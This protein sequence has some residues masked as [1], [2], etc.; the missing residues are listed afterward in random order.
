MGRVSST[1]IEAAIEKTRGWLFFFAQLLAQ[2]SLPRRRM[3]RKVLAF[4]SYNNLIR[5]LLS[6]LRDRLIVLT[7]RGE[8]LS[9]PNLK[10]LREQRLCVYQT[11]LKCQVYK[12]SRRNS[13]PAINTTSICL[14]NHNSRALILQIERPQQTTAIAPASRRDKRTNRMQRD[15]PAERL[16]A[17]NE[18]R[19]KPNLKSTRDRPNAAKS[20]EN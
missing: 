16:S 1:A 9:L 18:A 19:K 14:R 3:I 11:Q 15:M 10:F 8:Y 5:C 6:I 12:Q 20:R 17:D 4:L 7:L 13:A 2:R